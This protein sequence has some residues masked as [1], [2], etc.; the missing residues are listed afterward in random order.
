M[1]S[2][3]TGIFDVDG[4]L[5]DEARKILGGRS[6]SAGAMETEMLSFIN[7]V[8]AHPKQI[9]SAFRPGAILAAARVILQDDNDRVVCKVGFEVD[10]YKSVN[11]MVAGRSLQFG[12][13]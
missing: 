8:P 2:P 11:L 9:A 6:V 4:W 10:R 1:D 7:T 3:L 13:R 5:P 12:T